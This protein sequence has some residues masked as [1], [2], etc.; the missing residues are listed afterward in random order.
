[1]AIVAEVGEPLGWIPERKVGE[2]ASV[3]AKG[4]G[5]CAGHG[6]PTCRAQPRN[7]AA[8]GGSRP[9]RAESAVPA[10]GTVS[11]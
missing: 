4:L 6:E 7:Q 2:M 1:M 10:A 5:L 11:R 3:A 9:G 8:A